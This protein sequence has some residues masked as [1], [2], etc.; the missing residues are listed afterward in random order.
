MLR[1]PVT[2]FQNEDDELGR[3]M[4]VRAPWSVLGSVWGLLE[5]EF[6]MT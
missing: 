6:S 2:T 4:R 1:P 3:K 5:E